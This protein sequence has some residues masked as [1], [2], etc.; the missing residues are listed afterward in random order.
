LV[1]I[2]VNPVRSAL[3]AG[4]EEGRLLAIRHR[5]AAAGGALALRESAG[6]ATLTISIRSTA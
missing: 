6:A 3:G 1:S 4:P 5:V 2:T